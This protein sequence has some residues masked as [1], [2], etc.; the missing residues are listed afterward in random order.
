[1]VSANVPRLAP[2]ATAP[3][4]ATAVA[5][6]VAATI[7]AT[8][9]ATVVAL[10]LHVAGHAVKKKERTNQPWH[11]LELPSSDYETTNTSQQNPKFIPKK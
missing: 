10:A 11:W 4:A 7:S 6:T 2:T 5:A 1:M 9:I 3:I 8:A